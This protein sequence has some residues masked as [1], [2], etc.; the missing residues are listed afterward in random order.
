[1]NTQNIDL[2]SITAC[3]EYC[4]NCEKKKIGKCPGCI[5]SD[6]YVPEWTESG[7]CKVHNFCR[8]HN[9]QFCG[10]CAQFPCGNIE[11][12]IHWNANIIERMNEL[13]ELFANEGSDCSNK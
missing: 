1:M 6:G 4:S 9:V 3:G 10:L 5:E 11:K 2:K 12:L 13:K 7:R 8:Q